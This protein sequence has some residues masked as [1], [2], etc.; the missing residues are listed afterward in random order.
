MTGTACEFYKKNQGIFNPCSKSDLHKNDSSSS[1][2]CVLPLR[3]RSV[4][5]LSDAAGRR[6]LGDSRV[7]PRGL[8]GHLLSGADSDG[9]SSSRHLSSYFIEQ[10]S[11]FKLRVLPRISFEYSSAKELFMQQT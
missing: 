9:G 3:H 5:V 1:S 10:K 11:P 2:D 6:P 4:R 8:R 7:L